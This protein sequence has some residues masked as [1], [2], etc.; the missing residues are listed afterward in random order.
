MFFGRDIPVCN[1]IFNIKITSVVLNMVKVTNKES[2]KTFD[3][4]LLQPSST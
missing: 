1:H 3:W 4:C 2:I